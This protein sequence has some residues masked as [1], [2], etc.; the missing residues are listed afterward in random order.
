MKLFYREIAPSHDISHLVLSFWEFAVESETR[1]P[2]IHEV[3]PDGCISLIY[4]RNKNLGIDTLFIHGLTLETIKTQVF[5]GDFFWGMKL[6]PAASA[7]ILRSNPS[8]VQLQVL[9]DSK[10]FA[11]LTEGLLEL[12]R[13][14]S[15]DKAIEIY[16]TKLKTLQI[17]RAETDEKVAEAIGIIEENRRRNKDFRN[18]RRGRIKHETIGKTLPKKRGFDAETVCTR[19]RHSRY[20]N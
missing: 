11:H 2:I 16:E 13:C 14:Q 17:H 3:F 9:N 1:E 19:A 4:R 20:G 10:P 15:V 5:A 7:K 8:D 6:S 12:T 18:R